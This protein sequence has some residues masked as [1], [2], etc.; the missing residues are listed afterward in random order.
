MGFT[1]TDFNDPIRMFD[2]RTRQLRVRIQHLQS[3]L[4]VAQ[5]PFT[6]AVIKQELSK[7]TDDYV[8]RKL[9]EGNQKTD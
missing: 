1:N 3:D 9:Q 6:K 7:A 4:V 2:A 5:H 8:Y